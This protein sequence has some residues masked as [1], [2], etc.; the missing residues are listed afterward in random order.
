ML[1]CLVHARSFFSVPDLRLVWL[2]RST[3]YRK[4]ISL[5]MNRLGST[6][7]HLEATALLPAHI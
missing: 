1:K 5:G 2:I 4:S 6:S 3:A 7:P